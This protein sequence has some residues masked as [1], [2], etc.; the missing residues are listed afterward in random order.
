MKEIKTA[1][2]AGAGALGLMYM[3]RFASCLGEENAFFVADAAR[4]ERYRR[5]GFAL[6]GEARRFAAYSPEEGRETDLFVFATKFGDLG[7]AIEEARPFVGEGTILLSFLNGVDS[8]GI[9][10]EAL[11]GARILYS[12][13]QGNNSAKSGNKISFSSIGTV[14][15]GTPGNEK[16]EDAEALIAFF[17]KAGVSYLF[18]KDARHMLWSKLMLNTGVNQVCAARG[19]PYSAIKADTPER[20]EMIRAMREVKEVA[21]AMG[22]GLA[23]SDLEGWLRILDGMDGGGYPSMAFDVMERK[24]TELDIF[25]GAVRRM[26]REAG[27]PTPANDRLCEDIARIEASWQAAREAE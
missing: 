23:E 8:E 22:I 6:N 4:V 20:A 12:V 1:A 26:G 21:N 24:K 14:R 17:E 2:I 19:V 15:F 10:A 13:V 27:V 5:D 9:I 3:D 25:G 11:P 16:G 7:D 18:S